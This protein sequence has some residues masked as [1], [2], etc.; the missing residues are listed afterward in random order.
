MLKYVIGLPRSGT[1]ALSFVLH[2]SNRCYV[3][4]GEGVRLCRNGSKSTRCSCGEEYLDCQYYDET[5]QEL[6][7]LSI[8]RRGIVNKIFGSYFNQPEFKYLKL[9]S[10]FKYID[11][12]KNMQILFA[13]LELKE[14]IEVYITYKNIFKWIRSYR[15]RVSAPVINLIFLYCSFYFQ[16]LIFILRNRLHKVSFV[17]S[18]NLKFTKVS[19]HYIG[20]ADRIEANQSTH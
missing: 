3:N 14:P 6:A 8:Y 5:I 9:L 12:S 1:T 11:S 7:F 15:R 17:S 2:E 20:G 10:Q 16:I 4:I 13:S 19:D 18:D